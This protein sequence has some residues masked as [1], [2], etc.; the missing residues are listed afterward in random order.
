MCS[1]ILLCLVGVLTTFTHLYN[2]IGFPPGPSNDESIYMRR[3]MHVLTGQGPQEGS[4]YDH[5][6]FSQLFLASTLGV[7]GYPKSSYPFLGSLQSVE[8]L[9]LIPR[10]LLGILAIIDTFLIYKIAGN[11][12]GKKVALIASILF[13]VMPLTWLIRR[14]WLEPIQLPFI[15]SSILFATYIKINDKTN[16]NKSNKLNL[17]VLFSGVFLGLAIFTKIPAITMIPLVAFLIYTGRNNLK[18][19]LLLFIPVILIP[20]IW[21]AYAIYNGQFDFWLSGVLWQTHRGIHTFF[22]SLIYDFNIDPL[23]IVLGISG[24]VFAALKRDFFLLFWFIPFLMFLYL[25]GFVSYWHIVPLLPA[26]CIAAARLLEFLF[27]VASRKKTYQK[28]ITSIVITAVAMFGLIN[29]ILLVIP[30]NNN[31]AY[32]EAAAFIIKYLRSSSS[33]D[34]TVISNPFYSWI[35]Q[36]ILNL[37]YNYVDY[38]NGD[39]SVKTHKVLLIVDPALIYILKN[40]EA[41]DLIQKNFN[42][43]TANRIANFVGSP[44]RNDQVSVYLYESNANGKAK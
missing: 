30:I 20:L 28:L 1:F 31:S 7:I 16:E 42:L 43:Y 21:P 3:S 41:A 5:P 14:V 12:Y 10:M 33:S 35:P 18:R 34:I 36:S 44:N 15:L 13:A 25:I 40:H 4:L 17:A 2:P 9:Y 32:F 27:N 6:Y 39:I 8:T 11:L 38:Y 29:T 26:L 23:L 22:S 19:L 37:D 24:A